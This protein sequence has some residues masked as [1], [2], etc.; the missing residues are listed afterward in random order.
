MAELLAARQARLAD[1]LRYPD[2]PEG[3]ARHVL[4]GLPWHK[5]V[6]VLRKL[7]EP[8]YRV[9]VRAGHNVG[10]SWVAAATMAWSH[11]AKEGL[12]IAT[13]PT[14]KSLK[15]VLFSELRRL[16]PTLPGLMPAECGAYVAPGHGIE[17]YTAESGEAFAGRHAERMTLVYDEA[18]KIAPVFFEVGRTMFTGEPGHNWLCTYNP[19]DPTS[20]VYHEECTNNWHVVTISNFDHP[21]IEAELRG[22]P[23]PYPAAVRLKQVVDEMDDYS[24]R[25][26]P[27]APYDPKEVRLEVDGEPARHPKG[28]V[29]RWL[30]G[31]LAD[32]RVLGRWPKSGGDTVWSE[33]LWEAVVACRHDLNPSWKVQ[34]GCDVARY[35]YDDTAVAVKQGPCLLHAEW[36]NGWSLRKTLG[37]LKELAHQFH[38]PHEPKAVPILV[39]GV[40]A[41]AGVIDFG[42]DYLMVD[43]QAG[44]TPT[45]PAKYYRLRDEL[46]WTAREHAEA[47]LI[48]VSRLDGQSLKRLK[49][50]WLAVQYDVT[51]AEQIRVEPKLQT[52]DKIKRSP[53]LA[54]AVNMACFWVHGNEAYDD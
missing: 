16:R 50:E 33:E 10:K 49:T 35:G 9:L 29:C 47:G 53:D 40:G 15:R 46:W 12:T 11:E 43:V 19:T 42:A 21:N 52:R 41:G 26:G 13:A 22:D 30:P 39:D 2:D 5:Q 37:R 18:T 51:P 45:A 3:Y 34:I 48:D 24:T 38:G 8:P 14:L 27:D 36:H 20:Q 44:A 4:G 7:T 23:V 17:G 32:I 28:G 31:A 54:D 1:P 25:L 6:E